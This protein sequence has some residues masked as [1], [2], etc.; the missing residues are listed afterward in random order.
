MIRCSTLTCLATGLALTLACNRPD[1]PGVPAGPASAKVP[2]A[3][4][5]DAPAS[6]AVAS[7]LTAGEPTTTVPDNEV[8][9]PEDFE[10]EAREK[11]VSSNLEVELDA[12]E[13]E[14]GD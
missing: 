12:L 7:P 6:E 11:L 13:K 8:P 4:T 9:T 1:S 5:P 10:D 14:I 2:A 3:R